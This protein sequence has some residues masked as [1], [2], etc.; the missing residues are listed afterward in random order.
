MCRELCLAVSGCLTVP[1]DYL[2]RLESLVANANLGW[3]ENLRRGGRISFL[4]VPMHPRLP[5][6]RLRKGTWHARCVRSD[7][8][9]DE[10]VHPAQPFP[11]PFPLKRPPVLITSLILERSSA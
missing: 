7:G 8:V 2:E 6:R 4:Q 1:R 10:G 11:L 5:R 9:G 3:L